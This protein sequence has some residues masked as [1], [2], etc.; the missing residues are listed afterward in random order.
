M[1]AGVMVL[2][3]GREAREPGRLQ[4]SFCRKI[5]APHYVMVRCLLWMLVAGK[6]GK[7]GSRK[8]SQGG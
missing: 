8:G 5:I 1:E 4:T 7:K 3:G 6:K 2:R